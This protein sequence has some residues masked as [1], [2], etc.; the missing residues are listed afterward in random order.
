MFREKKR[1]GN[2]RVES[3]QYIDQYSTPR[4]V[5]NWLSKKGFSEK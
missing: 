2:S 5:Q 4:E 3:E 1:A